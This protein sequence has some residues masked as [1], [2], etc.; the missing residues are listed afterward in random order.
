MDGWGCQ[1][2]LT[3]YTTPRPPWLCC[4]FAVTLLSFRYLYCGVEPGTIALLDNPH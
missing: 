2:R 3:C 1:Y 4:R